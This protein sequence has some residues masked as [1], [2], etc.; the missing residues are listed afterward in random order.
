[1][2]IHFSLYS[3][4]AASNRKQRPWLLQR[5]ARSSFLRR[6]LA[7][8]TFT[9]RF[10]SFRDENRCVQNYGTKKQSELPRTVAC[11]QIFLSHVLCPSGLRQTTL[12]AIIYL[13]LRCFAVGSIPLA[14]RPYQSLGYSLAGFTRSNPLVSKRDRH[15]GTFQAS[16]CIAKP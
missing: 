4:L 2:V 9:T 3:N 11:L 15:C 5:S 8:V 13:S 16:R 7:G 14:E 1:M 10:S 12:L 6:Q